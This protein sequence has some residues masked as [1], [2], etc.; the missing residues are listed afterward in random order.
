MVHGEN[1]T[2][3]G[4]ETLKRNR[5]LGTNKHCGEELQW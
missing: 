4:Q 2:R 5:S 3:R 1:G